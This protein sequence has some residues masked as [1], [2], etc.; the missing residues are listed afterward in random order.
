MSAF[1]AAYVSTLTIFEAV[2]AACLVLARTAAALRS[3]LSALALVVGRAML[4]VFW[5]VSLLA[6]T[7]YADVGGGERGMAVVT[8]KAGKGCFIMLE[9]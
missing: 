8:V 6:E 5:A 1:P 7:R 2:V 3:S 9:S 4:T